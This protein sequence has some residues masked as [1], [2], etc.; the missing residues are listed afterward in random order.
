MLD[1]I[2]GSMRKFLTDHSV[3][4]HSVVVISTIAALAYAEVP[5]FH[6]MVIAAYHWYQ[7]HASAKLQSCVTTGILLYIWYRNNKSRLYIL[8]QAEAIK[9]KS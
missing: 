6:T 1:K 8:T 2:I 5:A 4:A 3:T 7:V 9:D